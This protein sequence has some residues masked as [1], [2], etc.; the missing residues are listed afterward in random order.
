MHTGTLNNPPCLLGRPCTRTRRRATG[1]PRCLP[2]STA[3]ETAHHRLSRVNGCDPWVQSPTGRGRAAVYAHTHVQGSSSPA[4]GQTAEQSPA[5]RSSC[6]GRATRMRRLQ[7]HTLEVRTS[8]SAC[9]ST[10]AKSVEKTHS[11]IML[12]ARCDSSAWLKA[13]P[14]EHSHTQPSML[15]TAATWPWAVTCGSVS[16]PGPTPHAALINFVR[17]LAAEAAPEVS[18]V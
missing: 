3:P 1:S 17:E 9:D 15:E 2:C 11:V 18:S 14:R 4:W 7:Q 6:A 13:A 8:C 12:T 10:A 5:R 16:K